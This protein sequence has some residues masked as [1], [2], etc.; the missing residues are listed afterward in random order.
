MLSMDRGGYVVRDAAKWGWI[1]RQRIR[2]PAC[3][4]L[5]MVQLSWQDFVELQ[6]MEY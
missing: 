3:K 1:A 5:Y 2:D 6:T 4:L